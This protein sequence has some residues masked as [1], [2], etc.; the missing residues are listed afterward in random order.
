MIFTYSLSTDTG[1]VRLELGDTS[2]TMGVRPGGTNLTDEEIAVWLAAE[3]NDVGR[4]TARACEMLSRDWA[5]A[6]TI[7]VGPRSVQYGAVAKEWADRA[8]AL[9]A[10]YGGGNTAFSVGFD[11][12]DGYSENADET[13]V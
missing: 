1:K 6:A 8:A 4:T 9:R 7:S 12:V 13:T 11:R 5:K 2:T 3:S 10:Q